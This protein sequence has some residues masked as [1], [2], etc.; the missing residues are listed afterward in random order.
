[1]SKEKYQLKDQGTTFFDPET[2][3]SVAGKEVVELDSKQRKGKLTTAAIKAGGLIQVKTAA[4]KKEES[5]EK[6][7]GK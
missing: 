6:A 4:D 7:P 3:L 2:R 5:K 1:M